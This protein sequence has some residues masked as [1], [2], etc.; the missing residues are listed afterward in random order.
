MKLKRFL[1]ES[2]ELLLREPKLF[3]PKIA[4][5]LIYAAIILALCFLVIGNYEL[6]LDVLQGKTLSVAEEH[7]VQAVAMYALLLLVLSLLALIIDILANAMYPVLVKD[8]YAGRK[9]SLARALSEAFK[10]SSKV[11]PISLLLVLFFSIPLAFLS[12]YSLKTLPPAYTIFITFLIFLF[13]FVLIV[14]FYFLYAALMLEKK[15]VVESVGKE[16]KLVKRNFAMVSKAA[17]IPFAASIL[18]LMFSILTVL[19]PLFI[20]LFLLYRILIAV[21]YT[22]HMVLS[23]SIYLKVM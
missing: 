22:Y 18:S 17:I 23:S 1:K 20:L 19:E 12:V 14:L 13:Y 21:L 11:V 10:N 9:L 3:V 16:I 7:T 6:L 15:R 2:L 5:S 8:F 4:T